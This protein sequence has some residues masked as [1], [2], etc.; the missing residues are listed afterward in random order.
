MKQKRTI[1][2]RARDEIAGII[3]Q[4]GRISSNE[5]DDILKRHRVRGNA[6]AL[7]RGYR[8]RAGQRLLSGVRDE[9]GRREI[10]ACH[11][12]D[13]G[14]I[15]Y[16]PIDLCNDEDVLLSI[17]NRLHKS[18]ASLQTSSGKAASRVD[19]LRWLKQPFKIKRGKP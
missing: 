3:G 1:S 16:V 5:L 15:V 12:P 8:L 9:E 7:Q 4:N 14:G 11:D 6:Q 13:T 17:Q 19:K 2:T 10:L 18:I